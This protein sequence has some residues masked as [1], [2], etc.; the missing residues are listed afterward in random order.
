MDID[1][2][3]TLNEKILLAFRNRNKVKTGKGL[4]HM[5]NLYYPHDA[6]ARKDD[7]NAKTFVYEGF[8]RNRRMS[9]KAKRQRIYN[10]TTVHP[11]SQY[12]IEN[13]VTI[14]NQGNVGACSLMSFLNLLQLGGYKGETEAVLQTFDSSYTELKKERGVD[15]L[16]LK[17]L[18]ADD[19]GYNTYNKFSEFITVHPRLNELSKYLGYQWVRSEGIGRAD[20]R[21]PYNSI[22]GGRSLTSTLEYNQKTIEYLRNMIDNGYAFGIA[23]QD[24]FVAYVGYY[25][26]GFIGLGSYG[27]SADKGGLHKI[28]ETILFTDS[29]Y[30]FIFIKVADPVKGLTE[31][32]ATVTIEDSGTKKPKKTKKIKKPKKTKKPKNTMITLTER[33]EARKKK[34]LARLLGQPMLW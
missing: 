29:I 30:D 19:T 12:M 5:E 4:E 18:G 31:P 28:P 17:K 10:T 33:I 22:I 26:E 27:E 3:K 32:L 11:N 8:N 14:M 16:Y 13:E 7:P 1:T 25:D 24:H 21:G 34:G 9:H 23:W 15:K 2:T 20:R 6:N